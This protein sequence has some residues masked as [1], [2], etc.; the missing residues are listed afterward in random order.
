MRQLTVFQCIG[1]NRYLVTYG[2]CVE[3]DRLKA[4]NTGSPRYSRQLSATSETPMVIP[5]LQWLGCNL[6]FDYIDATTFLVSLA[7]VNNK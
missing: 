6:H 1:K 4:P 7:K 3:A 5:Y 2:C